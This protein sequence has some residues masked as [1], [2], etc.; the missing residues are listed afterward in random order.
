MA[1]DKEKKNTGHTGDATYQQI[2]DYR[3]NNIEKV[4]NELKDVMVE[5]KMQAKD[6]QDLSKK[7]QENA[8]G[9]DSLDVRVR[10]L[11]LGPVQ[12]K[13]KRWE[14][15]VKIILDVA[16]KAFIVYMLAK[17]GVQIS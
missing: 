8:D 14:D 17:I 1:A 12:A 16:V 5:N 15:I 6:I 11:E 10:A 7:C 4:L 13:A 2:V 9:I 3:L